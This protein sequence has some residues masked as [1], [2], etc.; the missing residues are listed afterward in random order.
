MFA[1]P[2][3]AFPIAW[4]I[5]YLLMG[6]A[7]YIYRKNNDNEHTKKLYYSQLIINYLWSI[8]FF[9]LKL[10]LLAIFWIILLLINVYILIKRLQIEEKTSYYLFIPYMIW[11]LFA[12]Y[13]NISIY[14]LN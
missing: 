11:L 14:L 5:I 3:I 7:Y 1:P 6:I 8:I 13:L 4:S 2:K 10:R 12:T 9:N